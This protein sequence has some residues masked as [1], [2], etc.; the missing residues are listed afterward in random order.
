MKI[1]RALCGEGRSYR[2]PVEHSGSHCY[3]VFIDRAPLRAHLL[4]SLDERLF[5]TIPRWGEGLAVGAA[6]VG[7]T[8][9]VTLLWSRPSTKGRPLATSGS[10]LSRPHGGDGTFAP[11]PAPHSQFCTPCGPPPWV[12]TSTRCSGLGFLAITSFP[13]YPPPGPA[14]GCLYGRDVLRWLVGV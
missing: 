8:R 9:R 5:H 3:P 12:V 11:P 4:L 14:E 13:C 7:G 6:Q 2:F 10:S 1:F